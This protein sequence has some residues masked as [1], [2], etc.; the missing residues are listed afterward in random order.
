[1]EDLKSDRGTKF[2]CSHCQKPIESETPHYQIYFNVRR[3]H[4]SWIE[5]EY[6][7]SIHVICA[8]CSLGFDLTKLDVPTADG[9]YCFEPLGD[10]LTAVSQCALCRNKFLEGEQFQAAL[11]LP[12]NFEGE[13][14]GPTVTI[15]LCPSCAT[16]RALRHASPPSNEFPP[17]CFQ[18]GRYTG[19]T[20]GIEDKRRFYVAHPTVNEPDRTRETVRVCQACFFQEPDDQ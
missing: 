7:E 13:Q 8:K 11:I 4:T 2:E 20:G 5:V 9:W 17:Y 10:M 3:L 12:V 15:S 6:A 16:K 19:Y 1:M 14:E 18:C